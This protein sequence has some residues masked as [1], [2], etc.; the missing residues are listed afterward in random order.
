LCLALHLLTW[1]CCSSFH[2]LHAAVAQHPTTTLTYAPEDCI[3]LIDALTLL[4]NSHRLSLK[5]GPAVFPFDIPSLLLSNV[6][7]G[8]IKLL[9]L[10][11]W[12]HRQRRHHRIIDLRLIIS[13]T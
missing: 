8:T 12:H 5:A 2:F 6:R 13:R 3:E 7:A 9:T 4:A 11:L 1:I 10:A